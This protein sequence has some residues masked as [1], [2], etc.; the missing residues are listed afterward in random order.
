MITRE[1]VCPVGSLFKP[2][3]IKGEMSATLDYDLE[4]TDLRCLILDIDGILVPFFVDSFRARGSSSW[5]LKIAGVDNEKDAAAL[6]N[7]EI[8]ALR[9]ELPD[10]GSEEGDGV[11]LFDLVGYTL[12]DGDVTVGVIDDIDDSTVNILMDI[13]TPAGQH[14]LV[15]FAEDCITGLDTEKHIIEMELPEGLLDLNE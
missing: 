8:Y 11:H 15:P 6:I 13:V 2:H 7:H 14:V 10:D 1:S 5:L 12:L 4:P 3:G 9:N